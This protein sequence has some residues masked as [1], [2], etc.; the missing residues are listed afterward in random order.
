MKFVCSS[1]VAAAG[2]RCRAAL[3]RWRLRAIAPLVLALLRLAPY[4]CWFSGA[5]IIALGVKRLL[6]WLGSRVDAAAL[7][8]VTTAP[9]SDRP[10]DN[11]AVVVSALK[12][13]P[14]PG[15][16]LGSVRVFDIL[17]EEMSRWGKRKYLNPIP[18]VYSDWPVLRVY[19]QYQMGQWFMERSIAD[20]WTRDEDRD[21]ADH[22]AL[23]YKFNQYDLA[24]TETMSRSGQA[25]A[26]H[27]WQ[28]LWWTTASGGVL[29]EDSNVNGGAAH[30]PGFR[31]APHFDWA[32]ES[33]WATNVFNDGMMHGAVY[34]LVVDLDTLE[35]KRRQRRPGAA[36]CEYFVDPK[37]V[38]LRG[39]WVLA[40]RCVQQ[41]SPRFYSWKPE[42][43]II[44]A[45]KC[46][47]PTAKFPIVRELI[48]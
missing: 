22:Q 29:L 1:M 47:A 46:L 23:Y 19:V 15:M 16:V 2:R 30:P 45:G 44:P 6:T 36:D 41:G 24:A 32:L 25:Y 18:A 4:A 12:T 37:N 31:C 39:L 28:G 40:D 21:S 7:A 35:G 5:A 3:L 14:P 9:L 34:D 33:A 8:G 10:S 42:L 48:F 27:F 17:S 38:R 11:I 13:P 20:M 26:G 43:E